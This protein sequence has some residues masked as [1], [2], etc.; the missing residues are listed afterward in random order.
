MSGR[1]LVARVAGQAVAFAAERV[2]SIVDLPEVTPVPRSVHHVL[3]LAALR[4]WVVTV[5]DTA[6]AIGVG[7]GSTAARRAVVVAVDG[8]D[9]ALLVDTVGDV[10]A[11]DVQPSDGGIPLG[12]SQVAAG[13]AVR[14][15]ER[16]LVLDPAAIL[17]VA[18]ERA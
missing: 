8:H 2:G 5:I 10:V 16:I 3:G 1:Y 17:N 13:Q 6:A 18:A 4:S 15:G 12:W 7:E 11:L 14:D 9:Y